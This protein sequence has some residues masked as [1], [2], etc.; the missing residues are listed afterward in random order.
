[1]STANHNQDLGKRRTYWPLVGS[2]EGG[3]MI[4]WNFGTGGGDLGAVCCFGY[5]IGVL[6]SGRTFVIAWFCISCRDFCVFMDFGI[7]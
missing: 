2:E 1:M 3:G 6:F 5:S 4:W 7:A